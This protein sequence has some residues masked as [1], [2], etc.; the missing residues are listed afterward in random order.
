MRIIGIHRQFTRK[1]IINENGHKSLLLSGVLRC[2]T[3]TQNKILTLIVVNN[4]IGKQLWKYE[5]FR[6]LYNLCC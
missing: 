2:S 5:T 6:Y 1:R 4:I 3:F